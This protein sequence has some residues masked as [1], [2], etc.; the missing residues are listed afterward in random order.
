M[1]DV[2]ASTMNARR[3]ASL[4][5]FPHR[6]AKSSLSQNRVSTAQDEVDLSPHHNMEALMYSVSLVPPI[7]TNDLA[8]RISHSMAAG[9]LAM[10]DLC[11]HS[12][13]SLFTHASVAFGPSTIR[14]SSSSSTLFASTA[15]RSTKMDSCLNLPFSMVVT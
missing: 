11:F 1:W 6:P 3:S 10:Y 12:H 9:Y 15:L 7:R 2:G 8:F 14:H 13:A 4:C 5:A